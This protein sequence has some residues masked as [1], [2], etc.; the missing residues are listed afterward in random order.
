M[1]FNK[2]GKIL[3]GHNFLYDGHTVSLVNE[4]K[5]LGIIFK[6]SGSFTEA[7]KAIF[8]IRKSL[9]SENMNVVLHMKLFDSCVKPI[10]LYCSEIWAM[11]L[12][13][14]DG[15]DIEAKYDSF[16]PNRIQIK[17]AKYI[18]V[19]HKSATNIAVLGELGLYPLSIHPLKSC[20]N[21]WLYLVNTRENSLVCHSYKENILLKDGLFN[22][23]KTFLTDIGFRHV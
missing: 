20:I 16:H 9:C 15:I 18:L 17:F 14:K 3:K 23:A 5:Y 8:C 7:K 2:S 12:I 1:I 22:K 13:V 11:P 4:Y 21:Y 19:V 10:L 6:P